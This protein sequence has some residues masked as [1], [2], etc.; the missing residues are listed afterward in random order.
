SRRHGI[1]TKRIANLRL[2]A[3]KKWSGHA[4]NDQSH[5]D[6]SSVRQ[7]GGGDL[8]LDGDALFLLHDEVDPRDVLLIPHVEDLRWMRTFA[9]RIEDG[10]SHAHRG[11]GRHNL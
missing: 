2:C 1:E 10:K 7:S 8:A 11:A 5:L 3:D 9:C 4:R 6:R